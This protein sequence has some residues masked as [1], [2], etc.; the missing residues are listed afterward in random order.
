M[1]KDNHYTKSANMAF[2]AADRKTGKK[3]PVEKLLMQMEEAAQA[4]DEGNEYWFAGDW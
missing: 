3:N 1:P 4:D 2:G